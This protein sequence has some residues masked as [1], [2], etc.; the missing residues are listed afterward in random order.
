MNR[1]HW[2]V[3]SVGGGL[4]EGRELLVSMVERLATQTGCHVE[5]TT[6]GLIDPAMKFSRKNV[7]CARLL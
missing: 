1:V 7:D 3:E 6:N 4:K 2:P 5:R